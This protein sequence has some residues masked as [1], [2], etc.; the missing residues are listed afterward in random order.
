MIDAPTALWASEQKRG[1]VASAVENVGVKIRLW[2]VHD[3]SLRFE[4]AQNAT[5]R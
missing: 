4:R 1:D 3:A 2:L 5:L